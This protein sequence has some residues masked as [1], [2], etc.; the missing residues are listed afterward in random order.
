MSAT[1]S[2]EPTM[3]AAE[4]AAWVR[5]A[6]SGELKPAAGRGRG[7]SGAV[8]ERAGSA[9]AEG[10][11]VVTSETLAMLGYQQDVRIASWVAR[12]CP[13]LTQADRSVLAEL[14]RLDPESVLVR[15][16]ERRRRAAHTIP[17]PGFGAAM[18]EALG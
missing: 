7:A 13:V 17:L 11:G 6:E 12:G 16:A 8:P 9:S 5:M 14:R 10:G 2:M 18:L 15:D 4:Q 3:T 1:D